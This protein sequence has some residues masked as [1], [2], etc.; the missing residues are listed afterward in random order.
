[1]KS[2]KFA[3]VAG[4]MLAFTF[5]F[6][7]SSGGDGNGGQGVPFNENSQIYNEDG[8]LF[9]G[10][11]IIEATRTLRGNCGD[12]S[13]PPAAPGTSDNGGGGDGCEWD[14]IRVGS[15]A[16]GI[17]NL[18]LNKATIPDEYLMEFLDERDQRFCTSYPKGIK[19][20]THMFV[21]TNSNG[22]YIGSL[23]IGYRD[24]QVREAISYMYFSKAGKIACSFDGGGD[25]INID[26]Q[27]G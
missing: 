27:A 24:K 9:T 11:G 25:I 13:V 14:H 19:I 23:S 6:S 12:P 17:V 4:I 5:T 2:T 7:C 18:E 8:S 22:D 16:N 15:V 26:A 3:Q 1:M 20:F 10:S 21:L